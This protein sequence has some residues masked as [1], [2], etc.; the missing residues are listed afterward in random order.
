MVTKSFSGRTVTVSILLQLLWIIGLVLLIPA[1]AVWSDSNIPDVFY[2]FPTHIDKTH[3]SPIW[4]KRFATT[5]L[6]G[7]AV[8]AVWFIG[9]VIHRIVSKKTTASDSSRISRYVSTAVFILQVLLT[10]IIA[11][12]ALFDTLLLLIIFSNIPQ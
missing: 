3:P 11:A 6:C 8:W 7:L 10:V 12:L 5:N 1:V 4:S 2:E 9:S